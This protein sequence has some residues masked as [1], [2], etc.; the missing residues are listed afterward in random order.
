MIRGRQIAWQVFQH[1]KV[2][3]FENLLRVELEGDNVKGYF[4]ELEMTMT[5]LKELPNDAIM[6]ALVSRQLRQSHQL[7]EQM[8]I[9]DLPENR[10][11]RNIKKLMTMM[12]VHL[13]DRTLRR[14]Q[15]DLR[16]KSAS[17]YGAAAR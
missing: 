16:N 7:R 11:T 9:Y 5:Q 6:G 3:D 1:Y 17:R 8:V 14:N 2:S 13:A 4:S 12:R 15:A 10:S